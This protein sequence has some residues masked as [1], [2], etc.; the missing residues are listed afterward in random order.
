MVGL[1]LRYSFSVTPAQLIES[2][3]VLVGHRTLL[4]HHLFFIFAVLELK[5]LYFRLQ[6]SNLSLEFVHDELLVPSCL[7][8]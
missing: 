8:A 1:E 7:L 5:L 3:L 2:L 6:F 4:G